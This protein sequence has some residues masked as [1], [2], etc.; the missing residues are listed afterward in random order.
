MFSFILFLL[1]LAFYW[2]PIYYLAMSTYLYY[3]TNEDDLEYIKYRTNL[4]DWVSQAWKL[5]KP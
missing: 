4:L 1:A 3:K 2:K 5:V